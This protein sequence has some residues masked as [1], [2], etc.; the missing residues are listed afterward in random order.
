MSDWDLHFWVWWKEETGTETEKE[1]E[2]L[3]E[4]FFQF[5]VINTSSSSNF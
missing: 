4:R 3:G 2:W 5:I 1:S